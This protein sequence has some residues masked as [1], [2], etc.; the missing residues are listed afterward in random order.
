MA[1]GQQ[2]ALSADGRLLY[3]HLYTNKH[4]YTSMVVWGMLSPSLLA[5]VV[6]V[7]GLPAASGQLCLGTL[8]QQL[9]IIKLLIVKRYPLQII[10]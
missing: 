1:E 5:C 4:Y 8:E 2:Q 7:L 3:S 9:L 10:N 6:A